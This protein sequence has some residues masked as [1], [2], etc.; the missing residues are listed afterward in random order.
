MAQLK[1]TIIK[2]TLEFTSIGGGALKV[3]AN[4]LFPVGSYYITESSSLDTVDKMNAYFGGTWER[5]EDGRFLEAG[6]NISDKEAGLPNITGYLQGFS[7]QVRIGADVPTNGAYYLS[8]FSKM[9]VP[10]TSSNSYDAGSFYFSAARSNSIYGKS[11]TVQPKSRVV[12]IYRRATLSRGGLNLSF[13]YALLLNK[14]E[15][16]C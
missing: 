1:D 3:I 14:E 2:G 8:D 10:G 11:T 13:I 9:K 15:P 6:S 16:I 4:L 5:L 12:Y 7:G